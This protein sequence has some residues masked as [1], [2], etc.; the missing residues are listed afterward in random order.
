M[1]L[2]LIKD[3]EQRSYPATFRTSSENSSSF[4]SRFYGS[5]FTQG[6]CNLY[7]MACP[8]NNFVWQTPQKHGCLLVPDSGLQPWKKHQL[9]YYY[10]NVALL[11]DGTLYFP[12]YVIFLTLRYIYDFPLRLCTSL[13][14]SLSVSNIVDDSKDSERKTF[15]TVLSPVW[16]TQ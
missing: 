13:E 12:Y 5:N 16:M 7:C 10:R 3:E 6:I 9:Q 14:R 8:R 15:V 2:T 1:N 11:C 4:I